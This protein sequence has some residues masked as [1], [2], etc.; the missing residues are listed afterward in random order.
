M[1]G[2]KLKS[3]MNYNF[4]SWICVNIQQTILTFRQQRHTRWKG[5]A[6]N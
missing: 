5:I 4:V 6:Q 3:M 2:E 1:S